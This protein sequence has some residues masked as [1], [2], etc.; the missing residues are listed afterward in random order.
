MDRRK[1]LIASAGL[2]SMA[3]TSSAFAR[4]MG[5]AVLDHAVPGVGLTVSQPVRALKLYF[6]LGVVA[7]LSRI[8]VEGPTGTTVPAGAPA[9]DPADQQIVVV[10]F[11]HPL[12]PGTYSV[13]WSVVSINRRTTTG[14][15]HFRVS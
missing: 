3:S 15:F 13:S 2:A 5:G 9:N 7:S 4:F 6:D 11:G 8:R 1:L 14:T 12:P 10:G